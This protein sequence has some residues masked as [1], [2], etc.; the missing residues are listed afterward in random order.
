MHEHGLLKGKTLGVDSTTLEANA[1][2]K[3]IVRK[4]S[5]D[6]WLAH[7]KVL[8]AAEGIVIE[9]RADAARW[10]SSVSG[11]AARPRPNKPT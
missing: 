10:R 1:A 7:L 4:D 9:S 3:S 11:V 5:G 8:A 6:D 2:M